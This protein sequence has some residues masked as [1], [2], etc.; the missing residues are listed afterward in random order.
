MDF[1]EKAQLQDQPT[2]VLYQLA[3]K[4]KERRTKLYP[5]EKMLNEGNSS[6]NFGLDEEE[7]LQ[8]AMDT[9]RKMGENEVNFNLGSNQ[10]MTSSQVFEQPGEK[11][12]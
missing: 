2:E 4:L 12:D 9:D 5:E 1:L 7:E 10:N 6:E 3:D 11:D 8:R